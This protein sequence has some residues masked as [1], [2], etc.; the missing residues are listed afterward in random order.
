MAHESETVGGSILRHLSHLSKPTPWHKCHY[1]C[2]TRRDSLPRSGLALRLGAL[3]V[4]VTL[5]KSARR[6]GQLGGYA[7]ATA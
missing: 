7:N 1:C 3:A 6:L 4:G 2:F 5:S